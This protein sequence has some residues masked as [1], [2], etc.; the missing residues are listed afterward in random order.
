[1]DVSYCQ[2]VEIGEGFSHLQN[3]EFLEELNLE[4]TNVTAESLCNILQKNCRMRNLNLH[5]AYKLRFE[6][7]AIMTQLTNLCP[8]LEVID[9]ADINDGYSYS[10]NFNVL[11]VCKNLRKL[12]IRYVRLYLIYLGYIFF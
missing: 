9:L 1:M 7:D 3:L 5:S 6:L 4:K 10:L 12:D 2:N 11:S 8:N